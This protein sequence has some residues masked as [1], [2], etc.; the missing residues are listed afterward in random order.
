MKTMIKTLLILFFAVV[1]LIISGFSVLFYFNQANPDIP[2]DGYLFTI[3]EGDTL[4]TISENLQENKL[5]KS[6]LFLKI[7]S[8]VN[9]TSGSLKKGIYMI[10]P[11]SSAIDI[12]DLIISGKQQLYSITIPEGWT[13]S[14]IAEA[15]EK[16]GITEG[17]DFIKFSSNREL[18]NK[19]GIPSTALSAEGFIYPDTYH[20]PLNFPADKVIM[21]IVANFFTEIEKIYPDF[22][23]LSSDELYNKVILA[24]IIEREYRVND[25]A[26]TIASVFYNRMKIPMPLQSCATVVY[27]LTEIQKKPYPDHLYFRDTEIDSPFNTYV[28]MGLPPAPIS[29]PGKVAITAVFYPENTDYLFFLVKDAEE[30]R[31]YFSKDFYEHSHAHEIYLKS[32]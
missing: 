13:I 17:N 10:E 19:A 21:H 9:N 3:N 31:H 8:R 28:N 4:N 7:W 30:G 23:E 22:K 6:S 24:S 12:H 29:N 32:N 1:I 26:S 20:F 5:I 14:K 11:E 25:E 2:E 27:V 15:F 16:S 18:L